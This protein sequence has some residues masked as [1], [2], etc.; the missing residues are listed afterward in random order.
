MPLT[1]TQI[2]ELVATGRTTR[3]RPQRR[4]DVPYP[5]VRDDRGPDAPLFYRLFPDVD[6]T[7]LTDRAALE[8]S[9]DRIYDYYAWLSGA[10]AVCRVVKTITN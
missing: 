9:S 8:A 3:S 7:P 5:V 10:D 2:T 6:P 4:T 1:A